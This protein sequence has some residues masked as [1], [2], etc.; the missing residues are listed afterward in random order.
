MRLLCVVL[1][2]AACGGAEIAGG[3][4]RL[5]RGGGGGGVTL[6][7]IA[8][9]PN[10]IS[11]LTGATTQLTATGTYSD[12]S[13]A[14]LTSA[15]TWASSDAT[16]ATIV[17]GS[18]GGLL[19]G[20]AIGTTNI[21]ATLGVV[22][23]PADVA[24]VATSLVLARA[25]MLTT[26]QKQTSVGV[27][28]S[29]AL[30]VWIPSDVTRIRFLMANR[31]C[32]AGDNGP[33]IS[34]VNVAAYKSSGLA[35]GQVTGSPFFTASSVTVPSGATDYDT[36]WI[37]L[38]ANRGLDGYVVLAY[39]VP[40][41]QT[42]NT[43]NN[44]SYGLRSITSAAVNPLPGDMA[45]SF[46]YPFAIAIEYETA[47][48]RLMVEGDSLSQAYDPNHGTARFNRSM[49][50]RLGPENGY[51]VDPNGIAGLT[52]SQAN[53]SAGHPDFE[54]GQLPTGTTALVELSIN[55]LPTLSGADDAAKAA[56][57]MTRVATKKAAL[58]NAGVSTVKWVNLPPSLAYV[59]N[60]AVRV[61]INASLVSTLGSGN[62]ADVSTAVA[63]PA[64]PTQVL[65]T[66]DC[67]DGTHGNDAYHAAAKAAIL[68]KL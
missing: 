32:A 21:T 42:I 39:S 65:G 16:K 43:N 67:G 44:I 54:R 30:P 41:G 5:P 37:T 63:N 56:D 4:V 24:T 26:L 9:A 45:L 28:F 1:L 49:F 58:L 6:S 15:V 12:A 10:P 17:S 40:T 11:A 47:A 55:D 60:D 38:G 7:S 51:A 59:A 23:S 35:D 8:I 50:A 64:T 13:T 62:V 52:L 53:D 57:F 19:T 22:S 34:G 14:N 46:S 3:V 68:A 27:P 66:L 29:C 61:L 2:L 48:V 31:D 25:R 20:V 36:G 33:A 18:G